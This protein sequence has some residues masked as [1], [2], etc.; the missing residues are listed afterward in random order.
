MRRRWGQVPAALTSYSP[1]T[2]FTL[3][4]SPIPTAR[5]PWLTAPLLKVLAASPKLAELAAHGEG[6]YA[7]SGA[8]ASTDPTIQ[9]LP[10]GLQTTAEYLRRQH[11]G[12]FVQTLQ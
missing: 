2:A 10:P 12:E 9:K 7:A 6:W 4:A 3:T 8:Y 11:T 5:L 1:S